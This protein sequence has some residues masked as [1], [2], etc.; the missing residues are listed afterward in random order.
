MRTVMWSKAQC[1]ITTGRYWH[2]RHFCC[3]CCR[4]AAI[5]MYFIW[6]R[7]WKRFL[8]ICYLW[9]NKFVLLVCLCS[10][11]KWWL[12]LWCAVLFP[13]SVF[14]V[15][16]I[17]AVTA[18]AAAAIAVLLFVVSL[19]AVVYFFSMCPPHSFD[20]VFGSQKINKTFSTVAQLNWQCFY[21]CICLS[22]LGLWQWWCVRL[23]MMVMVLLL[24]GATAPIYFH[25]VDKKKI[26]T[27][28]F[29]RN[30][31]KTKATPMK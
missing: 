17:A 6:W 12:G 21:F 14:W 2:C 31:A 29:R 3:C 27:E 9:W 28:S 18:A 22:L 20:S 10:H 16:A 4:F 25:R 1:I 30:E 15:A 26:N 24:L 13:F 5:S 19:F 8:E 7:R 11:S 23:V